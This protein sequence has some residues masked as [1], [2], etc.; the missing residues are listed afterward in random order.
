MLRTVFT[1]SFYKC[2]LNDYY[3]S[4]FLIA[5]GDTVAKEIGM[6]LITME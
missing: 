4:D 3:V 6:A 1:H 5:T 2:S